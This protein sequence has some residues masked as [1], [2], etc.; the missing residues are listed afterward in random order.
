MIRFVLLSEFITYRAI[1]VPP[2]NYFNTLRGT[3]SDVSGLSGLLQFG[4]FGPLSSEIGTTWAELSWADLFMGRVVLDR[5]V[6]GPSC[7]EPDENSG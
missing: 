7:P 5:L 3:W 2:S 4:R 1:K 6:F